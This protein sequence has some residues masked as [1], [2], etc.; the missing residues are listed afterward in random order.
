MSKKKLTK[1]AVQYL[2]DAEDALDNLTD[3]AWEKARGLEEG[4]KARKK[5]EDE[6]FRMISLSGLAYELRRL[7]EL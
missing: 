3:L 2:L 7:V 4:T 6:H 1:K 5:A